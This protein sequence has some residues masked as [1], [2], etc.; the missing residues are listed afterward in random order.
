M[1]MPTSNRWN[2]ACYERATMSEAGTPS[3]RT[4]DIAVNQDGSNGQA[5]V[6]L[7]GGVTGKGF[8]PGQSGNPKG[9]P[10]GSGITDRLRAL[11]EGDPGKIRGIL[12]KG[13]G[14]AG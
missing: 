9:R 4:E 12:V 7:F 11:A 8:L 13:G 1:S 2:H 14:R 3:A 6:K 5:N 10:R